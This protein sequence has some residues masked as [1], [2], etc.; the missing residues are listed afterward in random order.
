MPVQRGGGRLEI[1][2]EKWGF[3]EDQWGG[4][5]PEATVMREHVLSVLK[6]PLQKAPPPPPSQPPPTYPPHAHASKSA[7]HPS[8]RSR[9][10]SSAMLT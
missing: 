9:G 4:V 7:Q 6:R 2:V 3:G 8:T 10:H 1:P 5:V